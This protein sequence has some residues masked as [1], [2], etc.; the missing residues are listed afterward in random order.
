MTV[1]NNEVKR[2]EV[3]SYDI[4]QPAGY[5]ILL[6]N[7]RECPADP[8]VLPVMKDLGL[9]SDVLH[10]CGWKVSPIASH[11]GMTSKQF[12]AMFNPSD[13]DQYSCF[14]FHYTGHGNSKGLLLSD[15]CCKP[16]VDIVQSVS[17]IRSLVGKPKS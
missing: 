11:P 8:G 17:L 7:D 9:M 15:G 1:Y 3:K 2:Y 5:A 14:M 16:Y 4:G 13:F 12:D 6:G 10:S